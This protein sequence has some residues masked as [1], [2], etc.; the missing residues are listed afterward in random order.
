MLE[1]KWSTLPVPLPV[2]S[3]ISASVSVGECVPFIVWETLADRSK[4]FS[5]CPLLLSRRVFRQ[6]IGWE[7]SQ[8]ETLADVTAVRLTT[9]TM[10]KR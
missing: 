7:H 9:T 2:P 8:M 1:I 5:V 4:C 10:T 6:T 3:I